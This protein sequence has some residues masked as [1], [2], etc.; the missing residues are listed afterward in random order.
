MSGVVGVFAL[1]GSRVP[2]ERQIELMASNI[3][4]SRDHCFSVGDHRLRVEAVINPMLAQSTFACAETGS[5]VWLD[6]EFT[7]SA[8]LLED[9]SL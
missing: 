5:F 1:S 9:I 7:N 8:Q 4:T 6:G 3:T 2:C